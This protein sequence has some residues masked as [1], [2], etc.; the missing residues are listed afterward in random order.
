MALYGEKYSLGVK[1][2]IAQFENLLIS[3]GLISKKGLLLEAFI[4]IV[5]WSSTYLFIRR[6]WNPETFSSTFDKY[7]AD[8]FFGGLAAGASVLLKTVLTKALA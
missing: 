3:I 6:L 7:A 8:S 4:A 5:C 2:Y 1:N